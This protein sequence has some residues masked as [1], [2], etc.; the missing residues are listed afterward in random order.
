MRM[1]AELF[2]SVASTS[3]SNPA[4]RLLLQVFVD[5]RISIYLPNYLF[6]AVDA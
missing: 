4:L 3:A 1:L 2:S 6:S 5:Q